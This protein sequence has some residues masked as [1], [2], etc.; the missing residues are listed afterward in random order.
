MKRSLVDY[1]GQLLEVQEKRPK[2]S[3]RLVR[4][5]GFDFKKLCD[6]TG[7][8]FGISEVGVSPSEFEDRFNR[9]LQRIKRLLPGLEKNVI[10]PGLLPPSVNSELEPEAEDDITCN[11]PFYFD[12]V[13]R[14]Y[15]SVYS[16]RRIVAPYSKSDSMPG[17]DVRKK[18]GHIRFVNRKK[19]LVFAYIA[20]CMRHLTVEKQKSPPIQ[21][22]KAGF[23]V[24][25]IYDGFSILALHPKV[26]AKNHVCPD[27]D[28]PGVYLVNPFRAVPYDNALVIERIR[29]NKDSDIDLVDRSSG[30]LTF[31]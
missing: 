9:L 26:L 10:L 17:V 7:H 3:K 31:Y 16:R 1:Q 30:A 8:N 28:Y 21:L 13:R 4:P 6:I 11:I 24:A 25:G 20:D 2:L 15:G 14:G 12:V 29:N 22:V 23:S 5:D 19:W 27:I 18:T